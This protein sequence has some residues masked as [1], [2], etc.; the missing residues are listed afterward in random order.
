MK[1]FISY[2]LIL[3]ILFNTLGNLIVL[4][5]MH[6]NIYKDIRTTYI[7][8]IPNHNLVK[9]TVAKDAKNSIR[10]IEKDEF[11]YKDK[12]YDIVRTETNQNSVIYYCLNDTKDENLYS[13]LNTEVRKC[14][15]SNPV[16]SKTQQLLKK[17][18]TTLFYTENK[19]TVINSFKNIKYSHTI[20][21]SK[22]ALIDVLTPP[23][24]LI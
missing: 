12:M 5:S 11:I 15:N 6:Y 16:K 1:K 22:S 23:P 14:M 9:I 3:G 2:L 18:A 21:K 10:F 24:Q 13:S 19:N 20:N 8:N 17:I 4:K 7:N